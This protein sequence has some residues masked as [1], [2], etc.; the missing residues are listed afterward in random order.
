MRVS[1]GTGITSQYGNSFGTLGYRLALHDLVDPPDGESEL[2]QLQFFDTRFRYDFAQRS[3][4][5]DRL[6]FA[7][8]QALNPLTRYEHALSW[9]I[10]AFGMRLH[11]RACS[12]C[13]AHGV[14]LALGG[15]LATRDERLALFVMADGYVAFSSSVDGIGGSFIRLGIGPYAG[16]RARLPGD[17]VGLFT[18][19]WSYLPWQSLHGTYDL[20]ATVRGALSKNVAVGL[21][22]AAQPS[23]RELVLGS[24]LYF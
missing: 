7:E 11:D 4:T 9:R 8:L 21:E 6:T 3:L 14:D 18:A 10:R 2:S 19:S 12:D 23:S 17:L 24:Y 22:G 13:F 1:V 15:T 5:L 16:V 20:R